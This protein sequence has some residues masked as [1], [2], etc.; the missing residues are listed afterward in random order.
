MHKLGAILPALPNNPPITIQ[1]APHNMEPTQLFTCAALV[2]V[3]IIVMQYTELGTVGSKSS[4]RWLLII[5]LLHHIGRCDFMKRDDLVLS[6]IKVSEK[7]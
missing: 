7:G 4:F 5:I 6:K 2:A 1:T 3:L